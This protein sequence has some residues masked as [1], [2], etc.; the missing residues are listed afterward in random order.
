VSYAKAVGA[1]GLGV[2]GALA[3][4]AQLPFPD[5]GV[6][7]AIIAGTASIGAMIAYLRAALRSETS[8][9]EKGARNDPGQSLDRAVGGSA[10][11]E[12]RPRCDGFS[13]R[14]NM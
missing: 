3:I 6:P 7:A 12:V 1:G 13:S 9:T 10:G 2:A 5:V 4:V 11:A 8:D 14:L